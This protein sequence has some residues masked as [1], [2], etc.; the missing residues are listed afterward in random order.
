MCFVVAAA[1]ATTLALDGLLAEVGGGVAT[2][3]EETDED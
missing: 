1:A 2:N 3:S